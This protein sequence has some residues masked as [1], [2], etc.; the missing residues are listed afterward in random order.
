MVSVLCADQTSREDAMTWDGSWDGSLATNFPKHEK[1]VQKRTLGSDIFFGMSL[2]S[3]DAL[4]E[5][6]WIRATHSW[7]KT[8]MM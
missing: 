3:V 8:I 5:R 4:L 7:T 6:I 1:F 2:S